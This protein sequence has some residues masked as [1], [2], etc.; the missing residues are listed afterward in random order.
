MPRYPNATI[1]LLR[2]MDRGG[3]RIALVSDDAMPPLPGVVPAWHLGVPVGSD[4][5]FDTHPGALMVLNMLIEVMC[6]A[7]PSAT[8]H[9]LERLDV[10]AASAGTYWA[11]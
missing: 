7:A 2:W 5:T 11:P 9:R 4:L 6:N 10:I 3:Y 8:E 1:E